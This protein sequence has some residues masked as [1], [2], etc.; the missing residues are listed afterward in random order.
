MNTHSFESFFRNDIKLTDPRKGEITLSLNNALFRHIE[1]IEDNKYSLT[2]KNRQN[3]YTTTNLAYCYWNSTE[4]KNRFICHFSNTE[5]EAE[6]HI[7][8]VK[9]F[10]N[11]CCHMHDSG[12][13]FF[14]ESLNKKSACEVTCI[15]D[16]EDRR[17]F[18]L[19]NDDYIKYREKIL[20]FDEL[21]FN[22]DN[23]NILKDIINRFPEAKVNITT[24]LN[25]QEMDQGFNKFVVKSMAEYDKGFSVNLDD[26]N[27]LNSLSSDQVAK[28]NYLIKLKDAVELI[29]SATAFD[30][31]KD[32]F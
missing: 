20:I 11:K 23:I 12:G 15:R 5:V 32:E 25:N 9:S 29:K 24:S 16:F 13:S 31:T 3:G 19:T 26:L 8:S 6:Q 14:L 4:N 28:F 18:F 2:I 30:R 27:F 7:K 21:A 17:C 22:K 10:I 1:N